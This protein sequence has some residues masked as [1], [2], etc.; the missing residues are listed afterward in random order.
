MSSILH[1]ERRQTALRLEKEIIGDP[2]P[3]RPVKPGSKY[4]RA[5]RAIGKFL[6]YGLNEQEL[7]EMLEAIAATAR[8][9]GGVSLKDYENFARNVTKLTVG[10]R[11]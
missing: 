2:P 4:V 6:R 1:T 7:R 9:M 8:R 5:E 3:G 10:P 11:S